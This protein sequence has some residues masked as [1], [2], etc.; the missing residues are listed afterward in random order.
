M[1]FFLFLFTMFFFIWLN[2]PTTLY[3][4]HLCP[5][6]SVVAQRECIISFWLFIVIDHLVLHLSKKQKKTM[7]EIVHIQAGQC[8]NQIGAKVNKK[9]RIFFENSYIKHFLVLGSY[10]GR[11]WYWSNWYISWWFRSST[12]TNQCLL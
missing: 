9:L 2:A 3:S 8:G 5:L 1:L 12:W 4:I 7:R 11:T 6:S 10:F